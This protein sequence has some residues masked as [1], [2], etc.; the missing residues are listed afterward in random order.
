MHRRF[1]LIAALA[2]A[3]VARADEGMWTF[4]HPPL[5][6]LKER[7]GF[8]P[9]AAW[10]EHVRLAALSFGGGS[11][12]FVSADGLV[13]TNHHVGRGWVQQVSGPGDKDYIRHGFLARTRDQELKIPGATL[14]TLVAMEPVTEAVRASVKPGMTESQ[15][16]EARRATLARLQREREAATGLSYSPV[17]LY[18]GGEYWLY[19][20]KVHKDIRLVMAPETAI[21]AFGGDPDNFTYPRHDLDFTLFRVYENDRPYHPPHHLTW[22]REGLKPG[23]LTFVVG[24]PGSTQR[25]ITYAQ[26]CHAR[27]RALPER[28]A[29][30]ETMRR[31]LKAYAARSEEQARQV[32]TRIYGV[33]NSLKALNGY[34]RGLQ[35]AQALEAIRQRER[36]LQT[37]VA[38]NPQL[39]SE[40]GSSWSA[41][42]K[43][44]ERNQDLVREARY[45]STRYSPLL[46]VAVNLVNVVEESAKPEAH[47]R[48]GYRTAAELNAQR[49][50]LLKPLRNRNEA[51]EAFLLQA[52]LE[53]VEAALPPNHPFRRALLE[54][55]SA[56]AVVQ[57][58]QAS[59]LAD[60]DVR[61]ALPEG[62]PKVLRTSTD[63]MI[64][65]ARRVAPL[66]TALNQR[67]EALNA[68]LDEHG[69]RIARARFAVLGKAHYPDATGTL[70]I[71][72]GPVAPY[73]ANGTLQQP[74][75]TFHGLYDRAL[76]WGPEAEGGAW[77]LPPRWLAAKDRLDLTTPFNFVHAVDIIGGNSGSPV[78]NRQGEFV[79][80]IFDGNIE[81]LPG[82]FY[83][84]GT[85]NRG[86]SLDARAIL[87]ALDKVYD[88][89]FLVDELLGRP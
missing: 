72:F 10:L 83:Y 16:A 37:K 17:I 40:A 24:H 8:E 86:V 11:G 36:E 49:E 4:D 65:L 33:E 23:D 50:A 80:I 76:A 87:E 26:M 9:S 12:S 18:Q 62:G 89:R 21:A 53:E 31:Q 27:D 2:L 19:G 43:A 42:A 54:G 13:I 58:L 5:K 61:K 39:A 63:P 79:G 51:L 57:E 59:R 15:A 46:A 73:P 34:L 78:L 66:L 30:L 28:L 32:R 69:A 29:A 22:S 88:A 35:N 70:R 48:K 55:R 60:P 82:N 77:A 84:D 1:P 75:T 52:G 68:I 38:S 25:F 67:Q 20:Y 45:V 56:H 44:L 71:T 74:F 6:Q 41:I 85:V 3:L 14:R 81:M 64:R 47:R 7:Y